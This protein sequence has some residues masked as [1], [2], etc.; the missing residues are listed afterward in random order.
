MRSI[1]R[2]GERYVP[3]EPHSLAWSLLSILSA[4]SNSY[5]Q[6]LAD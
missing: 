3:D 2:G 5:S 1:I 6:K 4:C